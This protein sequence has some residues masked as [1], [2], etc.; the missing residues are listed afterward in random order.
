MIIVINT[1][2]HFSDDEIDYGGANDSD[3]YDGEYDGNDDHIYNDNV[4][5]TDDNHD[6]NPNRH[7]ADHDRYHVDD[8]DGAHN[9]MTT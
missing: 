5:H 2:D 6:N 1:D 4:H 9:F 8:N 3:D 7:S